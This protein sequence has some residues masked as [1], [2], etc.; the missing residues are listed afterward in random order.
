MVVPGNTA[1]LS[2]EDGGIPAGSFVMFFWS[3][4]LL[5]GVNQSRTPIRHPKRN[6]KHIRK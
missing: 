4:D 2:S 6:G 3:L 1:H 5:I